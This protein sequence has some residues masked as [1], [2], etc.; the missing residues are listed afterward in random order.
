MN[1]ANASQIIGRFTDTAVFSPGTSYFTDKTSTV[2][3][4]LETPDIPSPVAFY[5][6]IANFSKILNLFDEPDIEIV[7]SKIKLSENDS[8]AYFL[9]SDISL[10]NPSIDIKEQMA[11]SLAAEK[12]L[13]VEFDEILISKLKNTV[14]CIPNASLI[15]TSKDKRVSL[16][17]KDTGMLSSE[18]HSYSIDI[19]SKVE[20]AEMDFQIEMDPTIVSK[21]PK[22]SFK[23]QVAY[24]TRKG[25]FRALFKQGPLNI[26]MATNVVQ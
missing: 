18:S 5:Q 24:S 17:I 1:I 3:G 19:T 26:V 14:A 10:V 23:L 9:S 8:H 6:E 7:G 11:K 4:S 25:S 2:I 21:M 16:T 20:M 12:V 22:G 15:V 13:V